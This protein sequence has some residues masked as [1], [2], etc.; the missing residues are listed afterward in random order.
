[1]HQTHD[2]SV[3]QMLVDA[4]K[5]SPAEIRGHEDQNRLIRAM[6]QEGD[7]HPTIFPALFP[8]QA[9][10]A[11]L[12]CSDG[13]WTHVLESEMELDLSEVSSASEWLG[14]IECRILA[15]AEGPYDNYTAA[16]VL[17]QG[18]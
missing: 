16:A 18:A 5:I 10:D 14:K 8:L 1:M 13:V 11:V 4:G 7:I 3:P 9:G 15:R 2:H 17:F 6:G 12:L